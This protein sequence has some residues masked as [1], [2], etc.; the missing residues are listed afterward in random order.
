MRNNFSTKKQTHKDKFSQ[1]QKFFK[2]GKAH[3]NGCTAFEPTFVNTNPITQIHK[4][5]PTRGVVE[6]KCAVRWPA[7]RITEK[8]KE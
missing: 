5:S 8:N 6:L 3:Y 7:Q 1:Y 2:T 4:V